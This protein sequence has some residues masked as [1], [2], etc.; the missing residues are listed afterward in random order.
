[1]GWSDGTA[2]KGVGP[3]QNAGWLHRS[4]KYKSWPCF[5]GIPSPF[6]YVRSQSPVQKLQRVLYKGKTLR[7]AV[8]AVEQGGNGAVYYGA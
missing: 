4:A 3:L 1:M 5:M 8:G 6:L 7:F 2:A